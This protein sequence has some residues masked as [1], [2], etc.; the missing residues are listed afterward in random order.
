MTVCSNEHI[1]AKDLHFSKKQAEAAAVPVH[2]LKDVKVC[3]DF[4]RSGCKKGKCAYPHT[5]SL[6]VLEEVK[7]KLATEPKGT[8]ALAPF[9]HHGAISSPSA[10]IV[11]PAVGGSGATVSHTRVYKEI[12]HEV[13]AKDG[14]ITRTIEKVYVE[15]DK[16]YG[17]GGHAPAPAPVKPAKMV[18]DI[19][20]SFDT[21]GSM[22]E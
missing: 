1:S 12:T 8:T 16:A 11:L 17:P 4:L 22:Y 10:G 15:D 18:F 20:L 7:A 14:T 19:A 21:T 5:S 6:E 2:L 9:R 13:I 3:I